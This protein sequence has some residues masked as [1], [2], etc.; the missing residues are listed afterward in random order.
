MS[1][2]EVFAMKLPKEVLSIFSGPFDLVEV[3]IA[4]KLSRQISVFIVHN[5]EA[6]R[7]SINAAR[8]LNDK[9]KT[10]PVVLPLFFLLLGAHFD[11]HAVDE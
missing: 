1:S 10:V 7:S 6:I 11:D 3:R 4:L 2:F 9:A 8:R 5:A